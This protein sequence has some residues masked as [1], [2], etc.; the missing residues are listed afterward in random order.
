MITYH[1]IHLWNCSANDVM[2]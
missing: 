2:M 1:F